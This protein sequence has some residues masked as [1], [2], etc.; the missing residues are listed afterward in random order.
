MSTDDGTDYGALFAERDKSLSPDDRA[1]EEARRA[2]DAAVLRM[3]RAVGAEVRERPIWP[4]SASTIHDIEPAAGI[5]FV[6]LLRD[7]ARR[8][9]HGYIRQAR[10]DGLTWQEVGQAL[11]LGPEAEKRGVSVAE[12][13][14]ESAAGAGHARPFDTLSFGWTCPA[15]QKTVTDYGPY[16]GHPDDCESGHAEGCQRFAAAVAAYE[17]QW[18]DEG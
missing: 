15:C 6:V 7:T 1:R 14:F 2:V 5:W 13:A 10:Q 9:I 18:A 16:N 8:K 11:R 12:A 17:A 3:A 4:G